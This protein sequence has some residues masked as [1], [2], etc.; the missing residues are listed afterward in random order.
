VTLSDNFSK[1]FALVPKLSTRNDKTMVWWAF[2]EFGLLRSSVT[3]DG[4]PFASLP[5]GR[6]PS[7]VEVGDSR[8]D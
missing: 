2:P 8:S 1:V 3:D 4:V 5:R 6:N 7:I